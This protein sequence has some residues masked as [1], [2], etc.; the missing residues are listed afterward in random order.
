[1]KKAIISIFGILLLASC[2][3]TKVTSF[4]DSEYAKSNYNKIA[5]WALMGPVSRQKMERALVV[6]LGEQGVSAISLIDLIPPTRDPSGKE[7]KQTIQGQGCDGVL[8]IRLIDA[9]KDYGT[10]PG[11]SSTVW[12]KYSSFTT[13]SGGETYSLPR[14][15]CKIDLMDTDSEKTVWTS[16]TFTA[17]QAGAGAD[18]LVNSLA[19]STVN[20]LK[21]DGLIGGKLSSPPEPANIPKQELSHSE[22]KVKED[23]LII[24]KSP[25]HSEKKI[26]NDGW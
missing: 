8:V 15:K 10:T 14:V 12:G 17:G 6:S 22:K 3:T 16:S 13:Y 11:Y 24:D 18:T 25:P 2:A 19:A 1:M 20:K 23:R 9:Y 7:I 21:A 26:K 5:V 4:K